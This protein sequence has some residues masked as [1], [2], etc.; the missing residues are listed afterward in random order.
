MLRVSSWSRPS[1]FAS[2]SVS[3]ILLRRLSFSD[4]VSRLFI[5]IS[6]YHCR[7]IDAFVWFLYPGRSICSCVFRFVC[8]DWI[9]SLQNAVFCF[10]PKLFRNISS[11]FLPKSFVRFFRAANEI[12]ERWYTFV[13]CFPLDSI[14]LLIQ[15]IE[16]S[17][18]SFSTFA[19]FPIFFSSV[20]QICR[21]KNAH[22][23]PIVSFCGLFSKIWK[24]K[25]IGIGI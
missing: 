9:F 20:H 23:F 16:W 19:T 7:L 12:V 22:V 15:L 21:Q 4:L 11:Y 5:L 14:Y 8:F 18:P 10:C 25:H 3:C 13:S 6:R 1:H 17:N 24:S 2:I